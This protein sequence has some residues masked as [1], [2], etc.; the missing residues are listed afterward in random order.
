M[1]YILVY[2][3]SYTSGSLSGADIT[4]EVVEKFSNK[5]ALAKKILKL[6]SQGIEFEVYEKIILS[7]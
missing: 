3:E 7:I 5:D 2:E 6:K 4:E 1:K